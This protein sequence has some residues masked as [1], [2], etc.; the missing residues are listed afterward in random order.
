VR[1]CAK[2]ASMAAESSGEVSCYC[3]TPLQELKEQEGKAFYSD[4]SRYMHGSCWYALEHIKSVE[5]EAPQALSSSDIYSPLVAYADI[6]WG[7][8]GS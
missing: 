4:R 7:H 2:E 8:G 6:I 5:P 1:Q 3:A